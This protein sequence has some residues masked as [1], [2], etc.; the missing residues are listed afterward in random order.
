MNDQ[1]IVCD[2]LGKRFCR[3]LRKSLW[4]AVKDSAAE[5][6][7]WNRGVQSLRDG[8]FWANQGISFSLKR[9]ECLGLIGHNGAGKT[10]L[11]KLLNGLI[12]PDVGTI[13]IRGRLG[14]LIALGAGFNPILTGRENIYINGLILG[15]TRRS[16]A[17]RMDR[18]VDFAGIEEFLDTPVRTY[19]SGMQV[20]L[21]FAIAIEQNPDI[22][23]LDEVLA[24]GDAAFQLKCF[25]RIREIIS[26]GSAAILVSH[27]E[28]HIRRFATRA[29]LLNRGQIECE[30]DV[31]DCFARYQ[32]CE[33]GISE[34]LP[35]PI[36]V[37]PEEFRVVRYTAPTLVRERRANAL[38]VPSVITTDLELQSS[39]EQEIYVEYTVWDRDGQ[40]TRLAGMSGQNQV[41]VPRGT[42]NL[43]VR[44]EPVPAIDRSLRLSLVLVSCR[45]GVMLSYLKEI[46]VEV[47]VESDCIGRDGLCLALATSTPRSS[48]VRVVAV[49]S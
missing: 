36:M 42:S 25:N 37:Q 30:G 38:K 15:H 44:I 45:A 29:L 48:P 27:Q 26:A 39:H 11:L 14:A 47:S 33:P 16:I 10:T 17:K 20:R 21:G 1:L 34:A 23:L 12:K 3:N 22:L 28:M 24:V 41:T 19:S 43:S 40:R 49:G 31:S 46:P 8:E 6:V 7:A 18:I 9:G 4:Y 13:A 35:A 32:E 5:L 2:G